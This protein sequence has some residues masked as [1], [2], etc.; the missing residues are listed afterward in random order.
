MKRILLIL[1][2]LFWVCA[3]GQDDRFFIRTHH[4]VNLKLHVQDS[5]VTYLGDDAVLKKLFSKYKVKVFRKGFKYAQR[6]KLKRTFFGIANTTAFR[7]EL[8][9]Q[10]PELFEYSESV[11]AQSLRVYEPNDYGLTATVANTHSQEA[12]LLDYYDYL[13]VPQAWY[14][15]TGSRDV[16]IGISDAKIDPDDIEFRGKTKIIRPSKDVKGHG[17]SVAATAAAQGDNG[18]GIPG[19]CYDCSVYATTYGDFRSF[20]QLLELSRLGAKVINCSWGSTRYYDTA[21][22]VINELRDNGTVIV[23]VPHNT[24]FSKSKGNKIYYPGGYEHVI[25]VGAIQHRFD[26]PLESLDIEKKNGKYYAKNVKNTVARTGGFRNNDPK[27]SFFL[28]PSSTS[29]MDQTVDIMAPGNFIIRYGRL[30]KLEEGESLYNEFS[31]T[32]PAAPL[33]TGTIGLMFSLNPCLSVDE[34]NSIIKLSATNI[35]SIP[36]NKPYKNYYGAGALHTGRAVKMVHD[37]LDPSVYTTIQNQDFSRWDFKLEAA[38]KIKIR[39]Q[40]FTDSSRVHF[41]AR[42]QILIKEETLL[43]PSHNGAVML[44]INNTATYDC[45]K[46]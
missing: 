31:A 43:L 12:F 4:E 39:Q 5:T 38:E 35:D 19:V 45:K 7:K 22:E 41:T 27:D 33:V 44:D 40:R 18:Y 42:Q 14:Y 36:A 3:S 20:N 30:G 2:M 1:S 29:N 16:I 8:V 34:V 37:M 26:S 25:S 17:M 32:S 10:R 28:Y 23:S 13:G 9:Q 24:K 6:D 46:D 15:T 11:D 21:Q